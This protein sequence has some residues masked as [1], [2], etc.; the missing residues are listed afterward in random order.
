MPIEHARALIAASDG[1]EG[2]IVQCHDW[3]PHVYSLEPGTPCEN[4]PRDAGAR[5]VSWSMSRPDDAPSSS[6]S[7]SALTMRGPTPERLSTKRTGVGH[8]M[9]SIPREST[10]IL[11]SVRKILFGGRNFNFVLH[12]R[13]IE[14]SGKIVV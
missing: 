5:L 12:F 4:A 3:V 14:A 6:G 9:N 10:L 1:G 11:H 2:E 8:L 13:V 7:E